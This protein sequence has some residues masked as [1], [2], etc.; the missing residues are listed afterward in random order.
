MRHGPI[1]S[2]EYYF[3]LS[4][5]TIYNT[6]DFVVVMMRRRRSLWFTVYG[7][8][9]CESWCKLKCEDATNLLAA[10]FSRGYTN[11][12]FHLNAYGISFICKNNTELI[13]NKAFFPSYHLC[14]RCFRCQLPTANSVRSVGFCANERSKKIKKVKVDC[15]CMNSFI[16]SRSMLC[17]LWIKYQS[18]T[19]TM[20]YTPAFVANV[21]LN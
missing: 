3:L 21:M 11:G 17:T 14:V 2:N 10:F 8:R 19:M 4:R 12:I 13:T 9:D 15:R 7:L 5:Q 20:K 6:F 1:L 16:L 18:V